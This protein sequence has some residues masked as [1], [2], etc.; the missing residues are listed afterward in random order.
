[1]RAATPSVSCSVPRGNGATELRAEQH[2]KIADGAFP[3]PLPSTLISTQRLG[4]FGVSLNVYALT[5]RIN[6]RRFGRFPVMSIPTRY[7]RAAIHVTATIDTPRIP[8][9]S[10]NS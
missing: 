9:D 7:M 6:S 8:S 10:A 4:D 2:Q 5:Q 1:M 3:M